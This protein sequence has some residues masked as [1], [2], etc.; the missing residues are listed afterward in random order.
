VDPTAAA[1]PGRV[2]AGLARSVRA[3]DRIPY[4]L[5][6]QLQWLQGLRSN[7]EAAVHRWNVWVLG[8][9]AERQ[10]NL[11]RSFGMRDADWRKLTAAMASILGGFTLLLLGWS[12]RR[13]L[14]ADPAQQAW[15]AFCRKL[16]ARGISRAPHEGPR[17]FAE[18][19]SLRWPEAAA[20]IREI[21][22]LY[23]GERYGRTP[24]RER[25]VELKR[26]VRDL[27]VA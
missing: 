13:W 1:V 10:R 3:G 21:A 9:S 4:L 25:V 18:R 11:M 2:S 15:L 7:W 12:L 22:A 14:Q 5:R 27:R 24:T 16:G 23:I 20:A 8:Y 6:P 26:R 17:D 19:A